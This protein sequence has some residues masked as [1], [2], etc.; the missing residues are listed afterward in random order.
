MPNY[1]SGYD[2]VYILSMP[3]FVWIKMYPNT[4]IEQ[5]P[6]HSSSCNVIDGSQ[7]IIIGGN[8]P[9][10]NTDCDAPAQYGAHGLDMGEQNADTSPVSFY[11]SLSL[12]GTCGESAEIST[13]STSPN[14]GRYVY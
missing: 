9:L 8:F 11:L 7:M 14:F 1:T 2:D 6:H 12:G 10:D 3:S 5:Y 4:T 13:S